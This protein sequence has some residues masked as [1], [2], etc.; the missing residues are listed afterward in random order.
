MGLPHP[1]WWGLSLGGDASEAEIGFDGVVSGRTQFRQTSRRL[2]ISDSCC[3]E[4]TRPRGREDG[5]EIVT[6]F[7]AFHQ[8][9]H[10][11]R[12]CVVRS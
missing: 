8:V 2:V 7:Y 4:Q 5:S 1:E 12:F 10:Y 9:P 3:D 6:G 11:G